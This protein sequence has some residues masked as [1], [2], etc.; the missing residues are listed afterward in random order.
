M[1]L[2]TFLLHTLRPTRLP[3]KGRP[4]DEPEAKHLRR[5]E[6]QIAAIG[7]TLMNQIVQPRV[8]TPIESSKVITQRQTDTGPVACADS[9]S[10]V[11][12]LPPQGLRPGRHGHRV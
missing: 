3:Q 12:F 9:Q 8:F 11:M 2:Q 1:M 5:I 4:M 7:M 10:G 6:A